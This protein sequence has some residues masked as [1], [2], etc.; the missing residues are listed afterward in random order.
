MRTGRGQR[1][2]SA[3]CG[4]P[5]P[6]PGVEP[7]RPRRRSARE[8]RRPRRPGPRRRCVARGSPS[9]WD[10]SVS[11]STTGTAAWG[12]PPWRPLRWRG[13]AMLARGGRRAHRA[14]RAGRAGCG[15][16]PARGPDARPAAGGGGGDGLEPGSGPA[17][18]SLTP[19]REK[20]DPG[21]RRTLTASVTDARTPDA[22]AARR[23]ARVDRR[24]AHRARRT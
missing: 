15:V 9:R 7:C 4:C 24:A 5:D 20:I 8:P 17:R 11:R 3:P 1:S 12:G 13:G 22:T 21:R 19:C 6:A 2:S 23:A 18:R 10:C 14:R 16:A